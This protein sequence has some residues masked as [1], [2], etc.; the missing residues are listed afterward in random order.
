M[1]ETPGHLVHRRTVEF[2][3]FDGGDRV[4]VVGRLQ[5]ARPWADGTTSPTVLHRMELRVVVRLL[6]MVIVEAVPAM[7]DYPHAECPAIEPAFQGLVGLSVA[8][9]Y[10]RE[11]QRRFGGAAGCSHL[12]H[13]ARSLGPVVVQALA[14]RRARA[15][16]EGRE[17]EYLS[18]DGATWLRNTCHVWAEDGVGVRK[19]AAGWRP[20]QGG[21]PAP[22]LEQVLAERGDGD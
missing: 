5:D 14:S 13:L 3:A 20:G 4:T 12:E 7:H 10:T 8:R 19:L 16:A 2:E 22:S 6:D 21:V 9:G 1:T 17:E 18:A 15:V 11:V